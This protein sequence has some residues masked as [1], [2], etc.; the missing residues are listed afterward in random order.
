MIAKNLLIEEEEF[1]FSD[2]ELLKLMEWENIPFATLDELRE[3]F[4]P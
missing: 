3:I 1:A 4:E 2:G